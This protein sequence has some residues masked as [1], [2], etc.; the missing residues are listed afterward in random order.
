MPP[1]IVIQA[2][3]TSHCAIVWCVVMTDTIN[4]GLGL[5]E[6]GAPHRLFPHT[7]VERLG[8]LLSL[9]SCMSMGSSYVY[10]FI[11]SKKTPMPAHHCGQDPPVEDG[12][13]Q[14]CPD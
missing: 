7:H 12:T 3:N 13:D 14:I 2:I 11:I 10:T 6:V 5:V 4:R 1:D 8:P 9:A